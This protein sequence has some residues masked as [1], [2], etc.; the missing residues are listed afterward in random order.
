V[1]PDFLDF[2]LRPLFHSA[3]SAFSNRFRRSLKVISTRCGFAPNSAF[4]FILCCFRSDSPSGSSLLPAAY[5]LLRFFKLWRTGRFSPPSPASARFVPIPPAFRPVSAFT[6]SVAFF[7]LK[8]R[9]ILPL[10]QASADPLLSACCRLPLFSQLSSASGRNLLSPCGISSNSGSY[11][12][13]S[14]KLPPGSAYAF[15]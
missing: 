14:V 11:T 10:S 3:Y 15:T 9:F 8:Q 7:P 1:K 6:P 12:S 2:H 4:G 5:F 13:L